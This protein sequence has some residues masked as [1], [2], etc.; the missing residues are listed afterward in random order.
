MHRLRDTNYVESSRQFLLLPRQQRMPAGILVSEIVDTPTLA[1]RLDTSA[2][3][4][5]GVLGS[6]LVRGQIALFINVDRVLEMWEQANRDGRLA[7]PDRKPAR[8]LA[9]DDTQFFQKLVA[10][11]LRSAGYEVSVADNGRNGLE[12]LLKERFDLVVCDIEMPVMDG[13]AFARAV[14]ADSR[15]AQTPLVALTTL[16]TDE[17]RAAA[18]ISGFDEY[19]VKLDRQTLL[20]TVGKLLKRAS[21]QASTSG[22]R[23]DE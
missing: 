12:L 23:S 13:H 5:D 17:S 3:R 9:I 8:I 15:V 1:V 7:L 4:A 14:R 2:F 19:E 22:T 10:E 6:M 16:N 20:A 11:H 18:A 21:R